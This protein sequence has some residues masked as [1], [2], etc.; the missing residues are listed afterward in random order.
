MKI[1]Q[2]GFGGFGLNVSIRDSIQVDPF[3]NFVVAMMYSAGPVGNNYII[4]E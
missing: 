2:K 3:I 1:V 4:H